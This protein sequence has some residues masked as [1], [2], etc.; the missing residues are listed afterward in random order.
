[1]FER[2]RR[3]IALFTSIAACAFAAPSFAQGAQTAPFD[4][5]AGAQTDAATELTLGNQAHGR[6][7]VAAARQHYLRAQQL[8]GSLTPVGVSASLNLIRAGPPEAKLQT[9]TA[10]HEQIE[11]TPATQADAALYLNL[12]HQAASLGNSGLPLA[13]RSLE[14]ARALSAAQP[15]LR[16]NLEALDALAQLYEDQQRY[17]EALRLS[18][19]ALGVL[20]ADTQRNHGDLHVALEWRQGRLYRAMGQNAQALGAYQRAVTQLEILRPDIPIEDGDGQPSYRTTFEPVY[21][22]LVDSLLKAV[23]TLPRSQHGPLL[24]QALD[25]VELVKQTELQDYL[26]DRCAVDAVKGGSA[27]VIPPRTAVLYPIMFP[28]RLE[29]LLETA[30]GISRFSSP[31]PGAALQRSADLLGREMRSQGSDYLVHARQL[32][33]WV[34]RPLDAALAAGSVDTLVVIPDGTLRTVPLAAL[35]D[36][37]RFAIEKYAITT[38]T[39]LSMTN[40]T[41]PLRQ[42]MTALVAGA[43]TFGG[44]VEKIGTQRADAL[45]GG[46]PP[47]AAAPGSSASSTPGALS[48]SAALIAL[49]GAQRVTSQVAARRTMRSIQSR[50]L[51]VTAE[52][53]SPTPSKTEALRNAL[54][55]PGVTQ[56]MLALQSILPGTRL[57]DSEFTVDAFRQAAT[58][59]QYRIVHVASHGIFGG[60]ADSSYILAYD[61]VLTLD[62]LQKMLSGEQ[63]QKN[64]IEIL[65]LSACE[66]AAGNDRAPL[67]ISGAAMK[68]RA[69]SVLGTLWPVDDEAAVTVMAQFY[70]GVA[71]RG[72]TKAQALQQAQIQLIRNPQMA[73]PFFWAPFALI[74]NWL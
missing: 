48:G 27:T 7:D 52:P 39:G 24:R 53:A 11:T 54:A 19:Q 5:T 65:S 16:P 37:S 36:G 25:A 43:S 38:A 13:W 21:L 30:S 66:T 2:I 69:K 28:D 68:A 40:T 4:S 63:F 50:N 3:S 45:L 14:K 64:P 18:Q 55:L 60:S 12:G 42:S 35:H 62:G 57:I 58:S 72:Q 74:G 44:V 29:L 56:E 15:G 71:Q 33:D 32:H 26:G 9:L 17:T 46:V 49:S 23:D 73:H 47:A 61:D 59:V 67:G 6:K 31:I 34:L 20:R 1:M 51:I 22:G 8:A 70:A 10:L 41:P